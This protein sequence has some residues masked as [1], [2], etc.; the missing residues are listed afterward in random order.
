MN[1]SLCVF[2]FER[3]S[4]LLYLALSSQPNNTNNPKIK[5]KIADISALNILVQRLEGELT[6]NILIIHIPIVP[7]LYMILSVSKKCVDFKHISGGLKERER[8]FINLGGHYEHLEGGMKF[9][10]L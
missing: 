2:R 4:G 5:S 7:C 9:T 10:I 1:P 6:K 8:Q 3:G